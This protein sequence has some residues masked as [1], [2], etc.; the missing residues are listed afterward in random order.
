MKLLV[1]AATALILVAGQRV[2]AQQPAAM[3]D[4]GC[5][6]EGCEGWKFQEGATTLNKWNPGVYP[7]NGY[8]ITDTPADCKRFCM[9]T[10]D[11]LN[12]DKVATYFAWVN[13]TWAGDDLRNACFCRTQSSVKAEAEKSVTT[14]KIEGCP[15]K[16]MQLILHFD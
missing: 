16:L 11:G 7:P 1:L 15:C 8:K 4:C 3:S 14:Y 10:F 2:L 12:G 5:N 13:D 9:R 6:G